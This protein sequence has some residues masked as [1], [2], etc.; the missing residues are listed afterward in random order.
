MN[1]I[2]GLQDLM[3]QVPLLVQ[4]LIVALAAPSRSSRVSSPRPRRLGR[5]QPVR[6]LPCSRSGQL[7]I[8]LRRRRLRR[9]HPRSNHHASRQAP[10]TGAGWSGNGHQACVRRRSPS[11]SRRA[12]SAFVASSSASAFPARASS[13]LSP[14]RRSSR[15]AMLVP[16][17]SRS[18]GYSCGKRPRSSC[19]PAS[20]PPS[21]WA[22][23]HCSSG[24]RCTPRGH[25]GRGASA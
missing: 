21:P 7:P 14:C 1:I 5:P 4:P 10:R 9:A 15:R 13:A 17:A 25:P 16:R 11:P 6:R 24:D 20:Q 3:S 12:A 18:A 19:G 23:S 2:E 22:F 8:R